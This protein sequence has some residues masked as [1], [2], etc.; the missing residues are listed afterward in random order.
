[1]KKHQKNQLTLQ[2]MLDFYKTLGLNL[3]DFSRGA[4]KYFVRNDLIKDNDL[5][6][7]LE[8]YNNNFVPFNIGENKQSEIIQVNPQID[9]R[10]I[11]DIQG[12]LYNTK[13]NESR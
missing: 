9:L 12:Q 3:D 5:S 1:M 6:T 10:E 11:G 8:A 2:G 7:I 4:S 13:L